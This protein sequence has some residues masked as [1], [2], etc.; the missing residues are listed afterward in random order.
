MSLI[1]SADSTS[2]GVAAGRSAQRG[3]SAAATG[4]G[5]GSAPPDPCRRLRRTLSY[6]GRMLYRTLGRTG[7]KVSLLGL[8]SGGASRLGQRYN[9]PVSESARPVRHALEGGGHL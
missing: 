3:T 8:G 1:L 5:G 9:L 6:S 4:G 2:R 7:L